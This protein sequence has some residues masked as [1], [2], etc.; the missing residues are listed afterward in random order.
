MIEESNMVIDS[1]SNTPVDSARLMGTD[2][3][4]TKSNTP[5]L[6]MN[7][8]HADSHYKKKKMI[9]I[10][11]NAS[12]SVHHTPYQSIVSQTPSHSNMSVKTHMKINSSMDSN[13]SSSGGK[14]PK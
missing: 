8:M 3:P 2:H 10:D 11:S 9:E 12:S 7:Y 4:S 13:K 6:Y 5:S 14:N 1:I